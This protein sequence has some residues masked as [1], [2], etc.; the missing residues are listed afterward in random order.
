MN[1][2]MDKRLEEIFD[3][4]GVEKMVNG[5]ILGGDVVSRRVEEIDYLSR[6]LLAPILH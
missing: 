1:M 5:S 4:F 6:K 3:V 2:K